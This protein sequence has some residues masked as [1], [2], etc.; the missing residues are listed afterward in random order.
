MTPNRLEQIQT[1]L[2][3]AFQ[4]IHL[5][6]IDE[7]HHHAGHASAKGGGHFRV[8]IIAAAFHNQTLIQ[9]HRMIYAALNHLMPHEIHALTIQADTP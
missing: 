3:T 7:S 6:I 1:S 2:E 8:V 5:E 9:R 4:P